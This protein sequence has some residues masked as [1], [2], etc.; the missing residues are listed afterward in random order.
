MN[1]QE[2]ILYNPMCMSC[3]EL[4]TH[5]VPIA[6]KTEYICDCCADMYVFLG[7]P[8]TPIRFKITDYKFAYLKHEP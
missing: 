7:F 6:N 4:A 2:E 5:K 1:P 8:G 3:D